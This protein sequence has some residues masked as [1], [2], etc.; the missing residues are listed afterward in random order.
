[1]KKALGDPDVLN[2]RIPSSHRYD[3]VQAQVRT[4]GNVLRA[5]DAPVAHKDERFK[6]MRPSTLQRLLTEA[7]PELKVVL[8]DMRTLE[9]YT[10]CHIEEALSYPIAMLS[11]STNPFIPEVFANKNKEGVVLVVYDYEEKISSLGATLMFEKG[12]DNVVLLSGGLRRYVEEGL[13]GVVGT[14]PPPPPSPS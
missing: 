13:P 1:M 12:L 11:R 14:P 4:G 5:M 3:D 7:E 6:R 10:A 9:E 2:K 8:L